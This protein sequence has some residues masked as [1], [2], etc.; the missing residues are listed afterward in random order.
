MVWTRF[1][2]SAYQ[3]RAEARMVARSSSERGRGGGSLKIPVE[4][5]YSSCVI[6]DMTS[7]Y[8][9][10]GTDGT[11]PVVWGMGVSPEAAMEDA[12]VQLAEIGFTTES[13]D[14]VTVSVTAE[15]ATLIEGG[16]VSTD[17][18]GIVLPAS[19]LKEHQG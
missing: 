13:E 5:L 3:A 8:A 9:V 10:V 12:R 11:Q 4:I 16:E 15:Q 1:L 2:N 7:Q 17:G 18:L 19:W 14:L 6:S